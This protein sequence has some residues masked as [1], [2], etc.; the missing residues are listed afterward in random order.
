MNNEQNRKTPHIILARQTTDGSVELREG[1]FEETLNCAAQLN[2]QQ[3]FKEGIYLLKALERIHPDAPEVLEALA[4]ALIDKNE[5]ES[6]LAYAQRLFK[7]CPDRSISSALIGVASERLGRMTEASQAL[8]KALSLAA[9][10]TD[11]KSLQFVVGLSMMLNQGFSDAE[12][13]A[14]RIQEKEPNDQFAWLALGNIFRSQ[15]KIVQALDAFNKVI[16]INQ[17]TLAGRIAL[18]FLAE[19]KF[20][21]PPDWSRN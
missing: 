7:L 4:I 15:G 20:G 9:G 19:I 17:N 14:R 13:L 6:A 21:T 8:D 12:K 2:M 18:D 11:T 1:N 16:Q 10:C 3:R 5:P